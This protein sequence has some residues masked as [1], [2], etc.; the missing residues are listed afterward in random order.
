MKKSGLKVGMLGIMGAALMGC[1]DG[2]AQDVVVT[3]LKVQSDNYASIIDYAPKRPDPSNLFSKIVLP[4]YRYRNVSSDDI[5][6]AI[7]SSPHRSVELEGTTFLLKISDTFESCREGH[8]RYTAKLTAKYPDEMMSQYPESTWKHWQTMRFSPNSYFAMTDNPLTGLVL[9]ETGKIAGYIEQSH[10][11]WS[12]GPPTLVIS[13]VAQGNS[14]SFTRFDITD[15]AQELGPAAN[16]GAGTT[17]LLTAPLDAER[18][19][20]KHKGAVIDILYRR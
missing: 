9:N 2:A 8:A 1:S 13:S 12:A 10:A 4:A 14:V 15:Y 11:N 18:F 19:L 17:C 20:N 16:P 6:D 5:L 7:R 3:D